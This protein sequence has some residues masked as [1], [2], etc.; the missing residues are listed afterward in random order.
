M[1]SMRIWSLTI[2]T[3]LAGGS[4]LFNACSSCES[5]KTPAPAASPAAKG[6]P[7]V[8]AAATPAAA[9][10]VDELYVDAEAEPDEGPPP[11]TVKFTSTVED[12]TGQVTYDGDGKVA[13]LF[14]RPAS[15]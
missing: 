5:P 8:G 15:P 3:L 2:A 10:P 1:S 11:L 14:I 12:A 7:Q 9:M 4:L 13:G 6:Q